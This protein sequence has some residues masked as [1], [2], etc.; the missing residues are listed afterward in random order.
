MSLLELKIH[1]LRNMHSAEMALDANLNVICG[2]NGSGKTTLLESIYLLSTGYSFRSREV[3]PLVS[4]GEQT[5]TVFSRTSQGDSI[6][7]QKSIGGSTLVKIN[8]HVC[9][10]NSELALFLPCLV[11][12]Q[13]I[14]Q[15]IDAGPSVRRSLLDWGMFHV[16]HCYH[17]LWKRYKMVVKQRNALLRQQARPELFAPWDEQL[18][19]LA[20]SLDTLRKNYFQRLSL[21]FTHYLERL[22][23]VACKIS[24]FKGWDKRESGK[25]LPTILAEQLRSDLQVQYTQSGAHQADIT[26]EAQTQKAKHQLSRGQQKIVLIALKLAQASLLKQ[27]PIYLI[28]D[29]TAELDKEHLMNVLNCLQTV[30]SQVFLTA[31]DVKLLELLTSTKAGKVFNIAEGIVKAAYHST[32]S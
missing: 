14:F 7:V 11:V 28:D 13:D 31:T 20:M 24:Y 16:E 25:D 4:H 21:A 22:T 12:Y 32:I 17:E 10:S 19:C 6:S 18:V 8:Q 23:P 30:K 3:V 2:L 9:R 29:I 15:I 1:H 5:L 27:Q 26:F